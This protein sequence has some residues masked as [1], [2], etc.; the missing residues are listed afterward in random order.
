[1]TNTT[2]TIQKLTVHSKSLLTIV[3][4]NHS[5]ALPKGNAA[6]VRRW[7]GTFIL[8]WCQVSSGCYI[9]KIIGCIFMELFKRVAF[10]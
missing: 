5:F 1:M 6:T 7:G 2:E 4:K 8:F 9:S 10:Y 3:Q